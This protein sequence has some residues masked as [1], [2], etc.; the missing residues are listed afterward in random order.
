MAD[1]SSAT[2]T[3]TVA[4][5]FNISANDGAYLNNS[6]NLGG[7]VNVIDSVDN[8]WTSST[9]VSV[10]T[11]AAVLHQQHDHFEQ[12]P[13]GDHHVFLRWAGSSGAVRR[14]NL[15]QHGLFLDL[16]G[17]KYGHPDQHWHDPQIE[18]TDHG[19][20]ERG[21]GRF[22][23][24]HDHRQDLRRR[25]GHLDQ[26]HRQFAIATQGN[27]LFGPSFSALPVV[28]ASSSDVYVYSPDA[29]NATASFAQ[30]TLRPSAT[31]SAHSWTSTSS[32]TTNYLG[33]NASLANSGN[34]TGGVTVIGVDLATLSNTGI[35]H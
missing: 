32:S 25:Y 6:G 16:V 17:R 19:C 27:D 14:R 9:E 3:G 1:S 8:T 11:S 15:E 26:P 31:T 33:G 13:D 18:R 29:G 20:G 34:I 24:Q 7:P 10:G 4:G 5:P 23:G 12:W 22:R 35:H 28:T 21:Y 30:S 2:N